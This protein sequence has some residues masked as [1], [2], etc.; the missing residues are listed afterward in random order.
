[1]K[2]TRKKHSA[3]FQGV[4]WER[5]GEEPHWGC[6]DGVGGGARKKSADGVKRGLHGVGPNQ[7]KWRAAS[8]VFY[9]GWT[10]QER[11]PSP[12]AMGMKRRESDA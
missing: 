2:S 11:H 1:M 3:T 8:T 10:N 7:K 6:G 4:W 9:G 12:R 5:V